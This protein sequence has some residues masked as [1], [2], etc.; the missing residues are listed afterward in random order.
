MNM[1]STA[2]NRDGAPGLVAG[3]KHPADMQNLLKTG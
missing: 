3:R 2:L 1:G